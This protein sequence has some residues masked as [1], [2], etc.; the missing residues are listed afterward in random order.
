MN[1]PSLVD[2][3]S[4][5]FLIAEGAKEI[6]MNG[7]RNTKGLCLPRFLKFRLRQAF[8]TAMFSGNNAPN[9][10]CWGSLL[11]GCIFIPMPICGSEILIAIALAM[12]PRITRL[13]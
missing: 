3:G 8:L 10:N 6:E 12:T 13:L 2:R 1:E 11:T 4:S 7:V 9:F 5:A